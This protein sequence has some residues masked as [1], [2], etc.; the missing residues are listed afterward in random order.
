MRVCIFG[1]SH[2]SALKKAWDDDL[3]SRDAQHSVVF[4]GS[5]R[6]TL[7]RVVAEAG[8]LVSHDSVTR[9]MLAT[10]S[11][12][13]PPD[14]KLEDFDLVLLHGLVSRN[15]LI[16]QFLSLEKYRLQRDGFVTS[17]LLKA[18]LRERLGASVLHHLLGEVRKISQIPIVVSPQPLLAEDAARRED[19]GLPA[20]SADPMTWQEI[21]A[22]LSAFETLVQE[23]TGAMDAVYLPQPQETILDGCFTLQQYSTGSV[24]LTAALDVSH[25]ADDFAHMNAQY[26][27]LVWRDFSALLS[28]GLTGVRRAA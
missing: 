12:S 8:V 2:L 28:N 10:T 13:N 22:L 15:W 21:G 26:G 17:G 4:Y 27:S 23:T 25:P 1:N 9:R 18:M 20:R 14:V 19:W 6:D 5:H 3:Q 24:R 11:G 7:K 16:P